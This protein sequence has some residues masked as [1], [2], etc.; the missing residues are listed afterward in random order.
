MAEE[1]V[2]PTG[3]ATVFVSN[4]S[5]D[6][7]YSKAATFGAVRPVTTGNYPIFKTARLQEEIVRALLASEETDF[8]LISGSS[9]VAALC[10]MIWMQMHKSVQLLLFDRRQECYVPRKLS[11]DDI[12]TEIERQRGGLL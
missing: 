3:T 4:M 5:R 6:H 1:I 12:Y 8:L 11:K 7:D 2:R 9:I 10:L